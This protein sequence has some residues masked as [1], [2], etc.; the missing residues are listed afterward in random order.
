MTFVGWTK[1][2]LGTAADSIRT[3]EHYLG[4]GEPVE[5]QDLIEDDDLTTG[6]IDFY[7]VW[8][9]ITNYVTYAYSLDGESIIATNDGNTNFNGAP[10]QYTCS[11]TTNSLVI[12]DPT[13]AGYQFVGWKMYAKSTKISNWNM[14]ATNAP[15]EPTMVGQLKPLDVDDVATYVTTPI[16]LLTNFGDIVMVAIFEPSFTDLTITK[17]GANLTSDPNQSFIFHIVGDAYNGSKVDLKVVLTGDGN[18]TIQDIP[19]GEY[20]I[21]EESAWS[22]R[23]E[24]ADV[25]VTDATIVNKVTDGVKVKILDPAKTGNVEFKN[26]RENICWLDFNAIIENVFNAKNA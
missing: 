4:I 13:R 9:P 20:T 14:D 10:T 17:T 26:S 24:V 12:P 19:V 23:Y 6:R 5:M 18:T 22:W 8:A 15:N 7:A 25:T 3:K 2:V 21:T 16:S 1:N 11:T